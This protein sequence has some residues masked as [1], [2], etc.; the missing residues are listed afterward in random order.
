[1]DTKEP[2]VERLIA[3]RKA[4]GHR[5]Y[6]FAQ[7]LGIAK[8][9]YWHYENGRKSDD[10]S[11]L[12]PMLKK[13]GVNKKWFLEGEGEMFEVPETKEEQTEFSLQ[14]EELFTLNSK[15]LDL[16]FG[17]AELNKGKREK[18]ISDFKSYL[19]IQKMIKQKA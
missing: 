12:F 5:Q 3:V 19:E 16:L 8:S 9:T 15:E 14:E 1:M 11:R 2:I 18:V 4:L 10:L 17:L 6:G 13:L 7:I